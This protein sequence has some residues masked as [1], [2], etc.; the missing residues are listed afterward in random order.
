VGNQDSAV[1]MGNQESAVIMGTQ[2]Y[3]YW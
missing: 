3:F 2:G 1:T